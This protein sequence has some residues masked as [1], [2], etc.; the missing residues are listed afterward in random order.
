MMRQIEETQTKWQS[1]IHDEFTRTSYDMM[2]N[3][4]RQRKEID[5]AKKP[6][7]THWSDLFIMA[8]I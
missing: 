5:K 2:N 4:D 6:N 1:A 8:S 7:T 3:L